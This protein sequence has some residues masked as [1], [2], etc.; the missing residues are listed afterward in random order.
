MSEAPVEAATEQCGAPVI[1]PGVLHN[2]DSGHRCQRLAGHDGVHRWQ[3]R[4]EG[5]SPL[6]V[7]AELR[8]EYEKWDKED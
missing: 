8:R 6:E 5:S 2:R 3:E 1:I 7:E 4:W